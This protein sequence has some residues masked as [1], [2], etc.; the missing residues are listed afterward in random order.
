MHTSSVAVPRLVAA[1]V[2]VTVATLAACGTPAPSPT[3]LPADNAD[4]YT[5]T[6]P[7]PVEVQ[8]TQP[9]AETQPTSPPAE[10]TPT[11]PPEE[12]QPTTQPVSADGAVLLQDRC[13]TCHG[14]DRVTSV[15][16]T[17][18]EWEQTVTGMVAKGAKLDQD[19]LETL[20]AYLAT[21]YGP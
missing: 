17:R 2:V 8:P 14:L 11:Q 20:I 1:L 3:S 4:E 7:P 16:K 6:P 18:E 9:P 15:R 13:G 19:E 10:A 12:Q 21:T 5:R